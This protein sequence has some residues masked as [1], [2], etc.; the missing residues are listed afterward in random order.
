[1][2]HNHLSSITGPITTI[3]CMQPL[4][5]QPSIADKEEAVFLTVVLNRITFQRI[6]VPFYDLVY[7]IGRIHCAGME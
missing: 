6:T 4:R 2:Q 3:N 1:M 5:N 7:R